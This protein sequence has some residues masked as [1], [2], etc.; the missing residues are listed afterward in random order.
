MRLISLFGTAVAT[1]I[2]G[3]ALA[4]PLASAATAHP[5]VYLVKRTMKASPQ[6]SASP[7][8]L[9]IMNDNDLVNVSPKFEII[10]PEGTTYS[11]ET[12]AGGQRTAILFHNS[13]NKLVRK[14]EFSYND[15]AQIDDILF[16]QY[17]PETSALVG[18]G[19]VAITYPKPN[20]SVPDPKLRGIPSYYKVTTMRGELVVAKLWHYS[21]A[22][23]VTHNNGVPTVT[24]P[25]THVW[26]GRDIAVGRAYQAPSSTSAAAQ[27]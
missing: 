3:L 22:M 20:F 5:N 23:V 17:S 4:G 16:S 21:N 1:A 12:G 15:D 25:L 6:E 14:G 7:Q 27:Q 24:A 10:Q 11:F 2:A 26:N 8:V 13:E 9:A 18:M 19:N